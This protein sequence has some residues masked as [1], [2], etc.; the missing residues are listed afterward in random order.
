MV[1]CVR[2]VWCFFV[3]GLRRAPPSPRQWCGPW[4]VPLDRGQPGTYM[5]HRMA[6]RR[7]DGSYG[8]TGKCRVTEMRAN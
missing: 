5:P 2:V 1:E 6:G 8:E 3:P 7:G 4:S